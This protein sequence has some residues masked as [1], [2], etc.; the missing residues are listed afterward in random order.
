MNLELI[1]QLAASSSDN[2]VAEITPEVRKL[3]LQFGWSLE[4]CMAV[5]DFAVTLR[6][7]T[8][9]TTIEAAQMAL[10]EVLK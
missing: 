9:E 3:G 1:K 4:C 6:H 2:A 5:A 7:S 8:I 10:G